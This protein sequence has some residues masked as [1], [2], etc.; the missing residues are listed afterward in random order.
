MQGLE[1]P[2][3]KTVRSL[4]IVK[5][6]SRELGAVQ[7][8]R[9]PHVGENQ[10]VSPDQAP[11]LSQMKKEL[12]FNFGRSLSWHRDSAAPIPGDKRQDH[13]YAAAILRVFSM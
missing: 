5:D 10:I 6:L 7:V 9:I 12:S 4:K 1:R 8:L 2:Q 13:G 3:P 11:L